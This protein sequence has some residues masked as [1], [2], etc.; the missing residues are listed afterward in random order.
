MHFAL[1]AI[2]VFYCELDS[3]RADVPRLPAAGAHALVTEITDTLATCLGI[4]FQDT[5]SPASGVS[6]PLLARLL[7]STLQSTRNQYAG[8]TLLSALL[9][10]PIA[11]VSP[12]TPGLAVSRAR[13]VVSLRG[14]RG[15]WAMQ[16]DNEAERFLP[17][18]AALL[19]TSSSL[20]LTRLTR[21]IVSVVDLSLYAG[22]KVV[23]FLLQ[24]FRETVSG[25]FDS[26]DLSSVLHRVLYVCNALARH[27]PGKVRK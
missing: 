13:V 2:P 18:I 23:R 27:G 22:T 12:L 4:W 26:R 1:G 20:L 6:P 3:N 21:M 10:D 15:Y 14:L 19:Q 16:V 9:P 11:S 5:S 25:A 7:D 17:L 24:S 8:V